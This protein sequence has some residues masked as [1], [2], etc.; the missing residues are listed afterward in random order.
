MPEDVGGAGVV[1]AGPALVAAVLVGPGV[2]IASGGVMGTEATE[3]DGGMLEAMGGARLMLDGTMVVVNPSFRVRP[4]SMTPLTMS[5]PG[6]R[7]RVSSTVLL[8]R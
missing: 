5:P 2:A 8:M 1:V 6:S 4:S 7:S 3:V